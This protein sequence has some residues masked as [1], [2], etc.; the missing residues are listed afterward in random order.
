MKRNVKIISVSPQTFLSILNLGK[1]IAR[2]DFSNLMILCLDFEGLPKDVE[3][4]QI[5]YNYNMQ[6]FDIIVSHRLFPEV[7]D[8][9]MIPRCKEKHKVQYLERTAEWW[10]LREESNGF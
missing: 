8:G 3:F 4:E 9:E 1:T 10:K 6:Q 5:N 7:P 2:Q